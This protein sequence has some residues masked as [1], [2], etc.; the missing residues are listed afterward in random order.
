VTDNSSERHT[1]P[2]A[3]IITVED[4]QKVDVRVGRI[5]EARPFAGARKPAYQLRID[6]GPDIGE[7]R[8]S[9]QL[10]HRYTA[11][12][13]LGREV[14]AVVNF[15][16]RQ[17]ANFLSEVLVLGVPD[18]NGHVVLVQPDSEVPLGGRLF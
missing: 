13:L 11:E 17:I 16:P 6:F 4:F 1:D 3:P 18:A 2:V 9:A 5:V 7:R 8:S 14:L 15:P 12:S 10:T